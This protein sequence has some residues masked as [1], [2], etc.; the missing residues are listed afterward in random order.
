MRSSDWSSDVCSSDL[1]ARFERF[2]HFDRLGEA[3]TRYPHRVHR[4]IAFIELRNE[5]RTQA[6]RAKPC[7]NDKQNR[8]P[9]HRLRP[10]RSEE[11]PSALHSLMRI[12]YVVFCLT[13]KKHTTDTHEHPY[14]K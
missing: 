6:R 7:Q 2:L 12:S 5:F 4:D 8:T 1:N 14:N 3:G 9:H 11:H 10:F 13:T